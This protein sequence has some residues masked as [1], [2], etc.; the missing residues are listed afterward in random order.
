MKNNT[1]MREFSPEAPAPAEE[2]YS[3]EDILREFSQEN[4]PPTADPALQ[5]PMPRYRTVDENPETQRRRSIQE[6]LP[7]RQIPPKEMEEAPKA[8][9][10]K[11]RASKP[12][13]TPKPEP[14]SQPEIALASA[15]PDPRILEMPSSRMPEE[16]P[17][18]A[19]QPEPGHQSKKTASKP[20]RQKKLLPLPEEAP[21]NRPQKSKPIVM[22]EVRYRQAIQGAGSRNIRVI[23]C[24]MI[25]I[26]ALILGYARDQGMMDAYR[27]QDLLGFIEMALL[28]L[29]A[30]LAFDVLSDGLMAIIRPS[31]Q[32][33]TLITLEVIVG[34][35][36]GFC[37][38]QAQRPSYCP[39]ICLSI[40][41][42]LWGLNLR[43]KSEANAMDAARG[44]LA[45]QAVVREPGV[46]QKLPGALVGSGNLQDFLQCNDQVPGPTRVLNVYCLALLIASTVV[47]GMT[48]GGDIGF[49][50]RNWTAILL[51][52]TPMVGA[53]VSTRPWAIAARRLREKGAALYGWTGAC[54]LSGKLAVLVSDRDLFP[55]ENLKLNGVKY[56]GGQ[57]PDRVVAYGAAVLKA[58]GSGLAP[59]FEDQVQLRGA[60]RYDAAG[61]R[62][63]ESGGVG[64][65]IN[66]ESVLVGTLRFM[67]SMGV[68][69]PAGT[70]VSQ[71]VYVAVDGTL[72]GVFAIHYGVTRGVAEGLGTLTASRGVTPVITAGDFM[73][74]EPFLKSKFRVNTD[75]VKIPSLNARAE[76]SQRQPSKDAKPCALVQSDRFSATALT[77]TVA[78]A[79]CTAVRW[80]TLVALTG[81]LVGFAIMVILTNLAAADVM[82]L[83]NLT[84]FQLLWAVPGILLSGWPRNV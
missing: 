62:R 5:T 26:F 66:G 55:R 3:L 29:T 50:F 4:A 7:P 20:K 24:L 57:T 79:L 9:P 46:C 63:Y 49:L 33:H 81:G 11:K 44:K 16:P 60:R 6:A 25:S 73:I 10:V 40:T 13:S 34:L 21:K 14:A 74:T 17:K 18:T 31:F 52:G 2:E 77:V 64:A 48:C 35:A 1:D 70:R 19:P 41:C 38:M 22:P 30:L 47:A 23:L 36:D 61:L 28:L 84:L 65:E 56:Y 78:R 8:K 43:H 39:L 54:R 82:S 76:L 59:I 51:A 42:A 69:M 45:G 12:E 37:A 75:R 80:G 67:Q 32:F 72:A 27:N 71:A 53:L 68:E 58:V 83:V 15:Q